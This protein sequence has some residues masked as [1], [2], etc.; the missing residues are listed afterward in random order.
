MCVWRASRLVHR[1]KGSLLSFYRFGGLLVVLFVVV[2]FW[3]LQQLQKLCFNKILA[4]ISHWEDFTIHQSLGDPAHLS[5]YVAPS[6][7]FLYNYAYLCAFYW[8]MNVATSLVKGTTGGLKRSVT[9]S[10]NRGRCQHKWLCK[11]NS[12]AMRMGKCITHCFKGTDEGHLPPS[13]NLRWP[14][15]DIIIGLWWDCLSETWIIE[16]VKMSF[17][18]PRGGINWRRSEDSFELLLL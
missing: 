2:W 8:Y 17:T 13:G 11:W 16:L 6:Y 3:N 9:P 5:G 10:S 7:I 14:P 18:D 1:T 12:F 4:A 15:S